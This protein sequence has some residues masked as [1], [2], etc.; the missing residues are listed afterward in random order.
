MSGVLAPAL[1]LESVSERRLIELAAGTGHR[2]NGRKITW[3]GQ[4]YTVDLSRGEVERVLRLRAEQQGPSIDDAITLA[5]VAKS[6]TATITLDDARRLSGEIAALAKRVV[7][8]TVAKSE[9]PGGTEL[10]DPRP[11]LDE[12]ARNLSRVKQSRDLARV[13]SEAPRVLEVAD[14]AAGEALASIAFAFELRDSKADVLPKN[15][16]ARH[17]FGLGETD[18]QL[19]HR[20]PWS[21]AVVDI[22]PGQPWR[23]RG[24]ILAFDIALG[25]LGL[26]RTAATA[27]PSRVF[28]DNDRS[29]FFRSFGAMSAFGLNDGAQAE[30][31]AA[32]RR[33]RA[34]VAALNA[35]SAGVDT[36]ADGI[37]M[38]GWRRR[39][40]IWALSNDRAAVPGYFTTTD[41]IRLGGA[42]IAPE[43]AGW[44]M[45]DADCY[46]LRLPPRFELWAITGRE[47]RGVLAAQVTDLNLH[48]AVTLDRLG[49]PA[50]LTK[51]VLATVLQDY[52]D[53]VRPAD[54]NDW[55]SLVRA[56]QGVP[57]EKIEDYIAAL[58]VNG[59]LYGLETAPQ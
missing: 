1:K 13:S 5:R 17:D 43:W 34:H 49:L 55:L 26:R 12:V 7:P 59:P 44:G 54:A 35:S 25:H 27:E 14:W 23:T 9:L 52:L 21:D 30:L 50:S 46:C 45:I 19:V 4:S 48:V 16:A 15:L 38:D 32:E 40:L 11:A 36:L 57:Q 47:Q 39:A 20:I 37:Q 33:G 28:N 22:V 56:A 8:V 10:F 31:A 3:E 53:Q 6:L 42:E 41:L 51:A 18:G 24:S 2:V 29:T 58:T